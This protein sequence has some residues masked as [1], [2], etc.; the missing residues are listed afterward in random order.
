MT[1]TDTTIPVRLPREVNVV[2]IGLPLF[3]EAIAEQKRPVIQVDWR[4]PGGGDT[5]VVAALRR[6]YGPHTAKIDAANKE[7]FRRLDRGAP[8]LVAVRTA[9][10]VIPI[11]AE[12]R[13]LL[14]CG[15]R[16][17][18]ED[19]VDPLR[20]SMRAAVCAE[21]WARSPEEADE[22]LRDGSVRL[23]PANAH[24][25]V[26]P[27]A[28]A[29]G[30]RT[31][32]WAVEL[33]D[34]GI[35]TYAPIGQG[36]GDVAW[37]GRDTPGAIARLVL[38]REAVGPVLAA[39]VAEAGPVDVMSLAAQAV[40][41]GDDV[42]V[43]TQAATNLL[44][45]NL[46]PALVAGDH[47]RRTEVATFLSGNHLL[48]LTLAMASARALTGWAAEVED[49][50]I[51]TGMARNGTGFAAWLAGPS[52]DWHVAPAPMV[53]RALY[54]PG[55]SEADAAPDIGDSSVLELV[56]LGG[57]AAA[58]SPAVAQI[59]GG[60][61]AAAAELTGQL[62]QVCV[63]NSSRFMIPVWGMKGSPVGV[64]VRKVVELGITPQVTTGILHNADGSGQV[65]AG[66]ATAPVQPFV[67]ALM[68][69]DAR[70]GGEA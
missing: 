45:R 43:R 60:T 41:M 6:L 56:G 61:M 32:V 1:T 21:G 10:D 29:M 2:N 27:M 5:T 50:S 55:R 48:F 46:L 12:G 70:L 40:A 63:G 34:A 57:A 66:V 31:P 15:P 36:P 22:L 9:A 30:P 23:E 14:H 62:D 47:P 58:G 17:A 68:A 64:D 53:E 51:V 39:A 33:A 18:I 59:V 49:S 35:T 4:I 69:L 65:G 28:T 38:L 11:L 7:V 54:Q 37:F 26:V 3:A 42:H 24:G 20:R 16:I 52:A 44:L 8:Q 19:T 25:V 67:E 13:V